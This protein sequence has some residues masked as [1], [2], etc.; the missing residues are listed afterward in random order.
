[1]LRKQK[2]LFFHRPNPRFSLPDPLPHIERVNGLTLLGVFL[3]ANFKFD[4]HVNKMLCLC[5]QRMYLLKQLKSRRLGIKQLHC[6]HVLWLFHVY[7]TLSLPGVASW[8]P[9][10][11]IELIPSCVKPISLAIPPRSSRLRIFCK[12][13]IF[14]YVPIF[15]A[16]IHYFPSSK[17]LNLSS[18]TLE[19][20]SIC[21]TAVI[22]CTK[23]NIF[24]ATAIDMFCSVGHYNMLFDLIWFIIFSSHN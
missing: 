24:F 17:L 14:T 4:E 23:I 8:V 12:M 18:T 15:T 10:S 16:F 21:L 20:A 19:L 22:N 5:S 1:M 3:N 2:S 9:T 6:L 7:F 13:Q 11:S